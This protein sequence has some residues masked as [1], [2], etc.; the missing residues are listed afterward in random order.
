MKRILNNIIVIV[1]ISS[2]A[3]A[4]SY[5]QDTAKVIGTIGNEK[6]GKDKI[7]ICVYG[8]AACVPVNID[9][10]VTIKFR[11]KE[12]KFT[13]LPFGLYLEAETTKDKNGIKV[14]NLVIDENKTV[15]CLTEL[16]EGQDKK[17]NE[18]LTSIKGVNKYEL[19]TNS[20]QIFIEFSSNIIA[21]KDLENKIKE[22]GFELE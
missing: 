11:N 12:T 17:L 4:N 13:E 9:S 5:A 19:N 20:N 22:A 14:K 6:M 8:T 18:L 7:V 10:T 1:F 15:I 3:I 16:K 2:F 21:Y